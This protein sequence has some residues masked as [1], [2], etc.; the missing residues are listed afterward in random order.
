M[1]ERRIVEQKVA[2]YELLLALC[3]ETAVEIRREKAAT[4]VMS[5]KVPHAIQVQMDSYA[6]F[7]G[8]AH[9][10]EFCA[11]RNG[12]ESHLKIEFLEIDLQPEVAT[13]FHS[14]SADCDIPIFWKGCWMPDYVQSPSKTDLEAD[15]IPYRPLLHVTIC[16][17]R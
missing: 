4:R 12:V 14:D 11:E 5:R 13:D 16:N 7:T 9:F 6:T 10:V 1:I 17:I 15:P 3:R 2:N 8:K